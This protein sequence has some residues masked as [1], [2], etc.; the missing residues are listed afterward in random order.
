MKRNSQS[1][2]ILIDEIE[3]KKSIKKK[4]KKELI[5]LTRQTRDPCHK[6]WTT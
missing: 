3:K 4:R 5:G 1:N 2:I 6:T